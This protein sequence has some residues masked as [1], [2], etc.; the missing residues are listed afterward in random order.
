M[1]EVSSH[2][3]FLMIGTETVFE[4]LLSFDHLMWMIAQD[5]FIKLNSCESFKSY[6]T[7]FIL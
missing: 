4:M 3:K 6:M 2:I 5:D 7:R 1:L